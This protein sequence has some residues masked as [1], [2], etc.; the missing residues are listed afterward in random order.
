[1]A[2]SE[3][4]IIKA[5]EDALG[6]VARAELRADAARGNEEAEQCHAERGG[7]HGPAGDRLPMLVALGGRLDD[8]ARFA[9]N[10]AARNLPDLA[11]Q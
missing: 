7:H 9:E 6:A 11:Q 8:E 10:V 4:A 1:M 3:Q 2:I 5:G